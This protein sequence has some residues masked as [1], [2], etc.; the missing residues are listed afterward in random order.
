VNGDERRDK[1]LIYLVPNV[2]IKMST[3][4]DSV[5]ASISTIQRDI[6]KLT[7]EDKYPIDT[8]PGRYGG[9]VMR[10]HKPRKKRH[11]SKED[12]RVLNEVAKTRIA[13]EYE[14]GVLLQIATTF[15]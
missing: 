4:A 8:I 11:L 6:L 10:K 7:V 13:S 2:I 1:I 3:L 9:V 12:V 15:V 14:A 5:E